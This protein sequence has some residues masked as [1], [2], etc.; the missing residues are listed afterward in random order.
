MADVDLMSKEESF[1]Q[2]SAITKPFNTVNGVLVPGFIKQ[3]DVEKH[4]ASISLEPS[5]VWIVTYPKA[6]T[7]WTQQIVKLIHNGGES[8]DKKIDGS[9]P[10]LEANSFFRKDITSLP[11]PCAFKSHFSYELLPCG[12]PNTTPCKYVY[13]VRNPKDVA[14]SF[15]FHYQRSH[16]IPGANLEW[17]LFFRNFIYGNLD[18]GDYFDHVLSWWVHK[19]DENVLFLTF[20]EMKKDLPTAVARIAKFIECDVT[21]EVITKVAEMTSF[22][23]MKNDDTTNYSWVPPEL[24]KP[25]TLTFMRKG[26]VGDWRNYFTPEQSA[27]MDKICRERLNGSGL[28]FDFGSTC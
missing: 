4:A 23:V 1:S 18:F 26:E 9:I 16:I 19:D 20:E 22:D 13:V 2:L 25:G 5:D 17:N 14:V 7:T 24:F 27:E 12:K 3:V 28:E 8:D 21:D 10:W 6:G 15:Y 11:K